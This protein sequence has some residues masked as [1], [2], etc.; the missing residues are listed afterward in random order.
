MV[1]IKFSL[2]IE[3][4]RGECLWASALESTV[5]SVENFFYEGDGDRF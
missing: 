3:H 5:P 1:S 4:L 2:K